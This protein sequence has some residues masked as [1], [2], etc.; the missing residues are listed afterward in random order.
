MVVH[1]CF[2]L[3]CRWVGRVATGAVSR[4]P[5]MIK[6]FLSHTLHVIALFNTESKMRVALLGFVAA[7]VF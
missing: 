5:Y 2:G 3:E 6:H 7:A 1:S 4:T